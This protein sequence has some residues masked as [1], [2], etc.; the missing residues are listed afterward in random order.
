[1]AAGHVARFDRAVLH[2]IKHL[3]AGDP[4][5]TKIGSG[6]C[7]VRHIGDIL[8]RRF[9]GAVERSSDL[10]KLEAKRHFNSGID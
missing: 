7:C 10:G 2:R 1:V 8:G 5:A 4:P 3:Q 6:T 9:A